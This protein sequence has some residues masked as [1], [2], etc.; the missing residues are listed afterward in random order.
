MVA[1]IIAALDNGVGIVGV[2]P[3]VGLYSVK[4]LDQN[5]SSVSGSI[6]S[7]IEWSIDN[8]MQIIN[9]SFGSYL[10]EPPEVR[11]ALERA[12][13]SG[14]VLVAG[15]GNGGDSGVIFAP[16]RYESVIAVGATDQQDA[17][18][19]F[20]ST[21]SALELMAP[22]VDILSRRWVQQRKQ[23]IY[24]YSTRHWRSRAAHFFWH[25]QQC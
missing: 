12:Y 9:M 1:G 5:G 3:E 23:H 10:E 18:A 8:G 4:V 19:D 15:A 17:R 21:G 24:F 20:S 16:A 25:H 11:A 2:A 22:G 13:Q 14:I 7:G 6:L